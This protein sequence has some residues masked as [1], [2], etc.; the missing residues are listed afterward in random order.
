MDF[1][2]FSLV[3]KVKLRLAKVAPWVADKWLP[4]GSEP[5]PYRPFGQWPLS[6]AIFPAILV[7]NITTDRGRALSLEILQMRLSAWVYRVPHA[8]ASV[9]S[10]LQSGLFSVLPSSWFFTKLPAPRKG[11][12]E[13]KIYLLSL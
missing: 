3:I 6:A 4:T 8:A 11:F 9:F 5:W 2:V 13:E 7:V 10:T 1:G 12:A